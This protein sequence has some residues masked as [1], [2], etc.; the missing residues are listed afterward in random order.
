[1]IDLNRM[2]TRPEILGTIALSLAARRTLQSEPNHTFGVQ[3]DHFILDGKPFVVRSGEM[4]YA[5]IPREYWRDRLKKMRAMGLNTLC[6]YSFW[7]MHEPRP[8]QYVFSGNLDIAAFIRTAHEEGLWVIVRPGPYSC[9]EWE[10]GGFPSWLL[11]TPDIRVRKT[12]PCFLGAASRYM[13]R[14]LAEVAPLQ[15]TR[16]CPVIMMQVETSTARSART[17]STSVQSGL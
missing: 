16:G 2:K 4:H 13:K 6:L 11:A 10:F 5:R 1:M 12:D 3:A 15:I 8:G 7:N 9:A 14:L 17:R